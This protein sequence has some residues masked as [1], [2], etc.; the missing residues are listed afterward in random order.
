MNMSQADLVQQ[1]HCSHEMSSIPTSAGINRSN[2]LSWLAG[3]WQWQR[4]TPQTQPSPAMLT[5]WLLSTLHQAP[6]LELFRQILDQWEARVTTAPMREEYSEWSWT[7]LRK[8]VQSQTDRVTNPFTV[9]T[10]P[11]GRRWEGKCGDD[12]YIFRCYSQD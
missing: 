4:Y 10:G 9:T 8:I 7:C 6:A 11:V 2:S 12:I 1:I 5:F 3:R